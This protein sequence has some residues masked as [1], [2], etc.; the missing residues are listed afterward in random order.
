LLCSVGRIRSKCAVPARGSVADSPFFR[1]RP[2]RQIEWIEIRLAEFCPTPCAPGLGG[3]RAQCSSINAHQDPFCC[4]VAELACRQCTLCPPGIAGPWRWLFRENVVGRG[5]LMTASFFCA[6][7]RD[8][9]REPPQIS[10]FY[11]FALSTLVPFIVPSRTFP[12]VFAPNNCGLLPMDWP[13]AIVQFVLRQC[14]PHNSPA[15]RAFRRS[16]SPRCKRR[17]RRKGEGGGDIKE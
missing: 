13:F 16:G 10:S 11:F 2:S 9:T 1:D 5:N 14:G 12:A 8:F 15:P 6:S 7:S 4:S 17:E 3:L